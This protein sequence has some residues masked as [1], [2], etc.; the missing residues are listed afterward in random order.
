MKVTAWPR[1]S[2]RLAACLATGVLC[3]A[4]LAQ[5]QQKLPLSVQHELSKLAKMCK[6]V[7]GKAVQSPGLLSIVEL[8]GDQFPDFVIDQGAFNCEGGA[9]LFSGSGGS[10][11]SVYAGTPDGQA[12]QAFSG[13]ASGVELDKQ[14]KPAAL[15]IRV[16]G[17]LCGQKVTPETPRWAYKACWRQVLWSAEKRSFVYAPLSKMEPIP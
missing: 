7:G 8:T 1:C 6:E 10:Q 13:G 4:A 5:A 3:G 9:S 14:S 2:L 12:M 17:S 16:G 15:K 11:V